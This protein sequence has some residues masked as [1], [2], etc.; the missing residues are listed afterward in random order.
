MGHIAFQ[1]V[2]QTLRRHIRTFIKTLDLVA[3]H[4]QF[5]VAIHNGITGLF[6]TF[7]Q[8]AVFAHRFTE[9]LAVLLQPFTE[10]LHIR[11]HRLEHS[12]Y[13]YHELTTQA[14]IGITAVLSFLSLLLLHF[15][16]QG[17]SFFGGKAF[18]KFILIHNLKFNGL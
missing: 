17:F 18:Q 13:I 4:F 6:L 3:F 10:H 1:I 12:P 2:N 9:R 8:L 7:T 5:H 16:N 14:L 15:R 11:H